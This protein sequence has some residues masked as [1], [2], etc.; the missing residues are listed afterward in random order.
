MSEETKAMFHA[1]LVNMLYMLDV[2]HHDEYNKN[3]IRQDILR[4][5]EELYGK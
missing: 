3:L 4:L 2:Q 5:Q 1:I